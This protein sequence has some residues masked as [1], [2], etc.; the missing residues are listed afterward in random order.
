M[1]DLK[2]PNPL[3][4]LDKDSKKQINEQTIQELADENGSSQTGSYATE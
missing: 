2:N 3:Q 4:R 1:M